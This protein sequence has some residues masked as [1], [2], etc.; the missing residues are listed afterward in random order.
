MKAVVVSGLRKSFQSYTRR[1][2]IRGSLFDLFQRNYHEIKAVD[3]ISFEI[4]QGELVGYIGPNGAGKSTTIKMLTG[5]LQ[6]SA[7][8]IDVLGFHPFKQ[9]RQYTARIGVVFGQRTQLWWDIAVKE[10]FDLLARIY[11]VKQSDYKKQLEMLNHILD[12]EELLTVPA[13]KLSLGQRMKCD[14]AAS[15]L[16]SPELLF[17]DEPTIGLDAV[18]KDSIRNFLKHLNS[19]AKTTIVLTTHDLREMEEL[20]ER[21]VVIDRG[22]ILYDGDLARVRQMPGLER[23][24]AVEFT[25][26]PPIA[27]LQEIFDNQVKFTATT[28]RGVVGRYQ[29]STIS[30]SM[31]LRTLLDRY[32]VSDVSATEPNIDEVVIK[33]YREG[34][35]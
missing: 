16:H 1:A 19:T 5:I 9:R 11:R 26:L 7:G 29:Q 34:M 4:A 18:A 24:I 13:R 20:C 2:G 15:L 25:A 14:L 33:L 12:L 23:T 21:I 31:I 35:S 30:T 32:D 28:P 8:E 22:K 27:E 17:L 3:G 6:P 10:S